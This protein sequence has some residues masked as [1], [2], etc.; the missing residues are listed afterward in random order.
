MF[1][2]FKTQGNRIG[3]H[4]RQTWGT[5]RRNDG[6]GMK[7]LVNAGSYVLGGQ[8]RGN[9]RFNNKATR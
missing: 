1:Q 4:T 7:R 9:G 3:I 6:F 2:T 5:R 8:G